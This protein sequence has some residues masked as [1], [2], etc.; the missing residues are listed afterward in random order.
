M[1]QSLSA[2]PSLLGFIWTSK[3]S[4]TLVF[5]SHVVRIFLMKGLGSKIWKVSDLKTESLV[6]GTRQ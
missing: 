1:D 4:R 6:H 3:T 5:Y 2:R